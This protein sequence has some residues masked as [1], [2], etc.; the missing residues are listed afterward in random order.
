MEQRNQNQTKKVTISKKVLDLIELIGEEKRNEL[1]G[2]IT[3]R[4]AFLKEDKEEKLATLKEEVKNTINQMAEVV[5]EPI[6][7]ELLAIFDD[8]DFGFWTDSYLFKL[9]LVDY[10]L[11]VKLNEEKQY[12]DSIS[13]VEAL[14][15]SLEQKK[16]LNE[17]NYEELDS[18]KSKI[19]DLP[20]IKPLID[21]LIYL[22]HFDLLESNLYKIKKNR[23]IVTSIPKDNKCAQFITEC[24]D[25]LKSELDDNIFPIPDENDY[26]SYV[27]LLTLYFEGK[28]Y[29]LPKHKVEVI[30]RIKGKILSTLG[31][32]HSRY[33]R[34]LKPD[35]AFCDIVRVLQPFEND[36]DDKIYKGM[37]RNE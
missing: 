1:A 5:N 18:I 30:P 7:F 35:N 11:K 34:T 3:L 6:I 32:P 27:D 24:F 19:V 37:R 10:G 26:I 17:L 9:N 29:N 8:D 20:G 33:K 23:P 12:V 13:K 16:E 4:I 28:E 21:T 14:I 22:K 15:K 36:S 2:K 31:Q 25:D